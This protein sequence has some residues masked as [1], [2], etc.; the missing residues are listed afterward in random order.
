MLIDCG[1]A[2]PYDDLYGIDVVIPDIS[3]LQENRDRILGICLTHGHEDH[4]GALPY[5]LRD[6]PVPVYGTRLT[7]GLVRAKISEH[8]GIDTALLKEYTAGDRVT[9]GPFTVQ[10]ISVNHSIP[11]TVALCIETPAGRIIYASDYKIDHTPIDDWRFDAAEFARLGDAGV[12][13]LVSDSTNAENPGFAPSEREVARAIEDLFAESTGRII[14]AMFASNIHRMQQVLKLC[15]LYERKLA[16]MGRSM[17]RNMDM[18]IQLGYV[19]VPPDTMIAADT[20]DMY[21]PEQVTV[22]TTGSQGEPLAALSR[23]SKDE[24][25]ALQIQKGDTVIISAKPIPGNESLVWRTVNRLVQRGAR[26]VYPPL[27]PVHTSGHACREELKMMLALVRPVHCVPLHGEPRMMVQYK[28]LAQ[29]M[30]HSADHIHLL[31]NGDV[32]SLNIESGAI[33]DKVNAGRILIDC[34][35]NWDISTHVLKERKTLATDGIITVALACDAETGEPV[36]EPSLAISGIALDSEER[37]EFADELLEVAIRAMRSSAEETIESA[38][39]VAATRER[40]RLAVQR[41]CKGRMNRKPLIV[42]HL[43]EV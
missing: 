9:L 30:G 3:F 36:S 42:V 29:E 37:A 32:L 26:V 17:K 19:D 40:I 5:V 41:A 2:F 11:E 12:L 1:L 4:I 22:L 7:M 28:Q 13:A 31:Q 8:S 23:I 21:D 18:A 33:T 39:D 14:I 6:I 15:H 10:P 34:G 24:Y 27:H 43:I 25:R 16:V 38:S 20:I 35:G